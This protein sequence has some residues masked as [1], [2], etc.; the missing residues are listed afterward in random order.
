MRLSRVENLATRTTPI[1]ARTQARSK[2]DTITSHATQITSAIRSEVATLRA[3]IQTGAPS[4]ALCAESIILGT[5][6]CFLLSLQQR[7]AEQGASAF[8]FKGWLRGIAV[9]LSS[10]AWSAGLAEAMAVGVSASIAMWMEEVLASSGSLLS[11]APIVD[12]VEGLY[13]VGVRFFLFSTGEK[14]L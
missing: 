3:D 2:K 6:P 10:S 7:K 8:N 13:V 1:F 9:A 14:Q 11:L 4:F 5:S 12:I